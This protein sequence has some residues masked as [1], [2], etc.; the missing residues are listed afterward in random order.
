M[1]GITRRPMKFVRDF[2]K[3]R[4]RGRISE[5]VSIYVNHHHAAVHI[6]SD[7]GRVC[8]PLIIVDNMSP[9]VTNKY[10]QVGWATKDN[11]TYCVE[12]LHYRLNSFHYLAFETRKAGIFWFFE[13][14]S[15]GILGRERGEWLEHCNI[16]ETD[17]T[18]DY[19][20]RDRTVYNF[21]RR[22]WTYSISTS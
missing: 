1:L 19:A 17:Y 7:G 9:K 15:C 21:R 8:R 22:G 3:L 4:R 6:A 11:T 10:I 18:R 5:F 13:A 16:W 2:R 20:F 12:K 14:R